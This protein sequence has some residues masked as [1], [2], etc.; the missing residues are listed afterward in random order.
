MREPTRI[1]MGVQWL[2]SIWIPP[3]MLHLYN[4]SWPNA[5]ANGCEKVYTPGS[6]RAYMSFFYMESHRKIFH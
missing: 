4:I 2:T 1:K 5:D 6:L 3:D